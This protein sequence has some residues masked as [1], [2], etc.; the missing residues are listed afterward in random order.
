LASQSRTLDDELAIPSASEA[1]DQVHGPV[2]LESVAVR[3][4]RGEHDGVADVVDRELDR[5]H[6]SPRD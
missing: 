6:E 2:V 5:R 3:G 4:G 1:D